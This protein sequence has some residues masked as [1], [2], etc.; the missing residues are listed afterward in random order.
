MTA[1]TPYASVRTSVPAESLF[2]GRTIPAGAEGV[3]L[4]AKSDGS[5]LV[6]LTLTPQTA[7]HHGDFVQVVLTEGQYDLLEP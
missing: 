3:V 4:E 6:E 2:D 5:C 1:A 7:D